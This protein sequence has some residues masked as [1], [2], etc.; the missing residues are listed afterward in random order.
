MPEQFI[1]WTM[2]K[3][4]KDLIERGWNGF[5]GFKQISYHYQPVRHLFGGFVFYALLLVRLIAGRR[6]DSWFVTFRL[7][8]PNHLE[9]SRFRECNK[10]KIEHG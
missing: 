7:K 5:N 1:C 10:S 4:L 3:D 6:G 2:G 8:N 9:D